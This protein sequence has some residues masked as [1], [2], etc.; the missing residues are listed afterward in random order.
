MVR[1]SF[2]NLKGRTGPKHTA[3]KDPKLLHLQLL[4]ARISYPKEMGFLLAKGEG[5]DLALARGAV[6]WLHLLQILK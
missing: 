2:P 4:F 3:Q 5:A 1:P 6:V